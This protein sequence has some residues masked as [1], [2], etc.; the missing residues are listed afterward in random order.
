MDRNGFTIRK[1]TTQSQR[2]P[3]ELSQKV[4]DFFFYVRKYFKMCPKITN[5][6]IMAMDETSCLFE[7]VSS[8]TVTSKGDKSVCMRT[9]GHEK[10]AVTVCLSAYASGDQV[11]PLVIFPGKGCTKMDKEL[12]MRKDIKV[13]YRD[14]AWVNDSILEEWV[15]TAFPSLFPKRKVLIWDSFRAHISDNTKK[16][17]KSKKIDSIIIPGGL[18]GLIQAPDVSWNAPFKAKLRELYNKWMANAPKTFTKAGN[19]R[20]PSRA[21]LCD[22]VVEAWKSISPEIIQKSFR[23]CGQSI[24]AKVEDIHCMKKDEK[25]EEAFASVAEF[26]DKDL[27]Y[28]ETLTTAESQ[29]IVAEDHHDELFLI[30]E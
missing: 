13:C 22:F 12:K 5:A 21:T 8:S 7:N 27:E 19:V 10:L 11:I 15:P 3:P 4:T 2:L 6:E 18:T 16:L 26:W 17:L 30:D 25:A 9:T 24:D 23:A 20:A 14:T 28:F 1:K 29:L